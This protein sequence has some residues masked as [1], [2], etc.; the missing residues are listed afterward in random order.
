VAQP[1]LVPGDEIGGYR[2]GEVLGAGGLGTVFDAGGGLAIKVVPH[3]IDP[4]VQRRVAREVEAL[5]MLDH[6]NVLRLVD[7]GATDAWSYLVMPRLAGTTLRELVLGGPLTPESAALLVM[8]AAHG[9][10][11]IHRAGLTHRD[12]KPD[13]VMLTDDGRV[14][15]IDLGLALAPDWTRQT[16]EGAIAGSLPYMAPEQIDGDAAPSTDVWALGVTWWELVTA[17]RPFGRARAMEEVAAIVAGGRP[18]IGDVDRR[19]ADDAA[20]LLERCLAREPRQRPV[21]GATLA[22]A[23]APIAYAGL[24]GTPPATAIARLRRERAVW[25]G[26]V[27]ARV[28]QQCAA[29]AGELAATGD[30]FGAVRVVDRGLAYTPDDPGLRAA[31]AALMPDGAPAPAVRRPGGPAAIAVGTPGRPVS[32]PGVGVGTADAVAPTELAA[33]AVGSGAE[34]AAPAP[35][36][37]TA[38]GLPRRRRGRGWLVAVVAAVVVAGGIAAAVIATRDGD[39]SRAAAAAPPADYPDTAAGFDRYAH[40]LIRTIAEGREADFTAIAR[41]TELPAPRGW[42]AEVF[43]AEAVQRLASEYESSPFDNFERSW[44]DLR[45]I[46]VHE[47]RSTV[48]TSRHVDPGDDLATGYQVIALRRM[49]RPVALYRLRLSAADGSKVFAI[50][51]WVHVDGRFRLVGKLKQL[52][53]SDPTEPMAHELDLLGELPVVEARKLMAEQRG[54]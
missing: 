45:E 1:G 21:D 48:T 27:A 32:A 26:E 6:P 14:V 39:G 16:T 25:E 28:S 40:D 9:V 10:G 23:I 11:A 24:A 7:A 53:P 33:R 4:T 2:L 22:A 29:R 31:L 13:N 3:G 35:A 47:S 54:E 19:I 30:V 34:H 41:T 37:A 38:P 49:K 18:A 51:S 8:Y 50:W 17:Q 43:G 44:D 52:E 15:I 12:L 36:V 20:A 42:F 46:V 5:R